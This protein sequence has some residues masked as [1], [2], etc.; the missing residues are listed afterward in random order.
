MAKSSESE[1]AAAVNRLAGVHETQ[2]EA[3]AQAIEKLAFRVKELGKNDT[4]MD[5]GAVE[6]LATAVQ[7]VARAIEN[8]RPDD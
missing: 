6:F 1:L 7:D 2:M 4:I 5:M 3:I 8:S